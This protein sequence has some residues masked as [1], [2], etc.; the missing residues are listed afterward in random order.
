MCYIWRNRTETEQVLT[1]LLPF[2]WIKLAGGTHR[3]YQRTNEVGNKEAF[4]SKLWNL[5]FV[6]DLP[7][8]HKRIL[9]YNHFCTLSQLV[10][11][12]CVQWVCEG[13]QWHL[14]TSS[15][16]LLDRVVKAVFLIWQLWFSYSIDELLVVFS[17]VLE[18]IVCQFVRFSLHHKSPLK[19]LL[20][21]I[22]SHLFYFCPPT[23][24]EQKER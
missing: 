6:R 14:Q 9:S 17:C 18:G 13:S 19:T 1:F 10:L 22:G 24:G 2:W 7:K 15:L 11:K 3:I 23:K 4:D 8:A 5:G 20:G 12:E 21:S 16:T